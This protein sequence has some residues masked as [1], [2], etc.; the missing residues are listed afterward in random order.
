[1][2]GASSCEWPSPCSALSI[3]WQNCWLDR[4]SVKARSSVLGSLCCWCFTISY[5]LHCL[6]NEVPQVKLTFFSLRHYLCI[7]EVLIISLTAVSGLSLTKMEAAEFVFMFMSFCV[8]HITLTL[9][10]K[11]IAMFQYNAVKSLKPS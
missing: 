1:V 8:M 9:T 4:D 11:V 6:F 7:I 10:W 3:L 5:S 2:A